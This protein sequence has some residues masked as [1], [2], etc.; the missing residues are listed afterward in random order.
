M[1]HNL[2]NL[3]FLFLSSYAK[4]SSF[5]CSRSLTSVKNILATPSSSLF[6]SK[7]LIW[8]FYS[9]ISSNLFSLLSCSETSLFSSFSLSLDYLC[10]S[11]ETRD[12][13]HT[14]LT[15]PLQIYN[16]SLLFFILASIYL[17]LLISLFSTK[18]LKITFST[19]SLPFFL[20]STL[21][22]FG[23]NYIEGGSTLIIF[24]EVIYCFLY[25]PSLN[26]FNNWWVF[27]SL[28]GN[29]FSLFLFL[30]SI[31]DINWKSDYPS[32]TE[33]KRARLWKGT[34]NIV[35]SDWFFF[36]CYREREG[37]GSNVLVL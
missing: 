15:L 19:P 22:A 8:T 7:S 34:Y 2:L 37:S 3:L 12:V 9:I 10:K 27:T 36:N 14:S 1:P 28:D 25:S 11:F 32:R 30:F 33:A 31:I 5:F 13:I 20:L 16:T 6:V 18:G 23:A 35:L 17:N 26:L 29:Y 4:I 24:R 21:T